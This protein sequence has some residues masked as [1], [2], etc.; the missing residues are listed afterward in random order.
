MTNDDKA[1]YLL[2]NYKTVVKSLETLD[3]RSSEY[4]SSLEYKKMVEKA[5]FSMRKM[6]YMYNV[7]K[8][9]GIHEDTVKEMYCDIFYL[10]FMCDKVKN[11][12]HIIKIIKNKYGVELVPAK[13]SKIKKNIIHICGKYF[14]DFNLTKI[15]N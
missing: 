8:M 13:I 10:A 4:K 15:D 9:D 14:L 2:K 6:K 12:A 7:S 5:L 3:K 1:Q 11:S